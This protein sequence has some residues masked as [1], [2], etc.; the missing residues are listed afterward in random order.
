MKPEQIPIY[1]KQ[2]NA[3]SGRADWF[4]DHH[5]F[6]SYSFLQGS[7]S[8]SPATLGP[9]WEEA[10]PKGFNLVLSGHI[11]LFEFLELPS[12]GLRQLI[13][14]DSG[15][16]LLTSIPNGTNN[17]AAGALVKTGG[18]NM[19]F[20]LTELVR[21]DNGWALTL[22]NVR[23]ESQIECQLPQGAETVCQVR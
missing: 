20:G 5:P 10:Q 1:V 23:G 6:W 22:R 21:K 19:S 13:A 12:K 2:L 17:E 11:H 15:T 14:G 8:V 7:L 16:Q 18:L 9:A 3:V 4:V